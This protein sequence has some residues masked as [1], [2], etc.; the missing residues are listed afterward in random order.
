MRRSRSI[1]GTEVSCMP[2]SGFQRAC[3]A[4]LEHYDE[5]FDIDPAER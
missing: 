1:S 3:R 2:T 5:R 4:E